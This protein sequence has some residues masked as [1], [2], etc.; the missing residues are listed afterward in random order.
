MSYFTVLNL[1]RMQLVGKSVWFAELQ[2]AFEGTKRIYQVIEIFP[3]TISKSDIDA[4]VRKLYNLFE[5]KLKYSTL[6]SDI[7]A[8]VRKLYSTSTT[9]ITILSM[10]ADL[11]S[12]EN[13]IVELESYGSEYYLVLSNGKRFKLDDCE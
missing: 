2:I 8:E 4:E 13:V 5:P 9:P 10:N 11:V 3:D 7:D 6:E 1:L 12:I